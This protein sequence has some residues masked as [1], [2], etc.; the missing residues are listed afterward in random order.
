[1]K[2]TITEVWMM[3]GSEGSWIVGRNGVVHIEEI[4]M[5]GHMGYIPFRRIICEDGS[6]LE[7]SSHLVATKFEPT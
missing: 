6:Q 5:P 7:I 1:M 2:R 3:D 4:Q